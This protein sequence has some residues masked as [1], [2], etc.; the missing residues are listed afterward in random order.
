MSIGFLTELSE[1]AEG[2]II[3]QEEAESL[4]S[5]LGNSIIGAMVLLGFLTMFVNEF[6]DI[7]GPKKYAKQK[8]EAL[9]MVEVIA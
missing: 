7:A 5:T 4:L 8:E 2:H 3:T 1:A 9:K 6:Y